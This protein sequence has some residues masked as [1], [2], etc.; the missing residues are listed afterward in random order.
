MATTFGV[1]LLETALVVDF[2]SEAVIGEGLTASYKLEICGI[3][4]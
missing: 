4:E 1:Q 2:G 3:R